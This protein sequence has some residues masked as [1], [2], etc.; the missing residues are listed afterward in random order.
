MTQLESIHH[1]ATEQLCAIE[2]LSL[3]LA[4]GTEHPKHI[5]FD[6][7]STAL[8]NCC[9]LLCIELERLDDII[10]SNQ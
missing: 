9:N 5:D 8:K 3:M 6:G 4:L 2:A 7:V 1:N 10:T